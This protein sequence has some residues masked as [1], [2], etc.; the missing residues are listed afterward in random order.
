MPNYPALLFQIWLDSLNR[1]WS[2]CWETTRLSIRPNFSV[3]PVRKN[4][5]GSKNDWHL[6]G[7][8][9]LCH[10]AK[11]GED[12]IMH[13]GCRCENVCRCFCLSRCKAGVFLVR[14]GH[15]LSNYCVAVYGSILLQFSLGFFRKSLP[16]QKAYIVSIFIA[17]WCHNFHHGFPIQCYYRHV[18]TIS[19]VIL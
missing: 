17:R 16:F 13:A 6:F 2:Y 3:H 15:S 19:T 11:L 14:G 7:L 12:R 9:M 10:R 5:I 1:L 4:C 18:L 8:D